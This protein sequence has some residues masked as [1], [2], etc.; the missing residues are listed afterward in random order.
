MNLCVPGRKVLSSTEFQLVLTQYV[1][2]KGSTAV[3]IWK[4]ISDNA[5][6]SECKVKLFLAT[7]VQ[8]IKFT[9]IL[10]G[11]AEETSLS[12][13]LNGVRNY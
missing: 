12:K 2:T 4:I 9:K 8:V 7:C 1:Y 11:R 6:P 3:E 10:S 13:E 5:V